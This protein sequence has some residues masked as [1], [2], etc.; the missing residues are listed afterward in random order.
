MKRTSMLALAALS[1]AGAANAAVTVTF[2]KPDTYIDMPFM[3][4]EKDQVL[5]EL[6]A[7]FN[8]LGASLPAGQTL[9]IEMLDID[10]AGRLKPV[11]HTAREL[12][13]LNGGAD[14][15]MLQFRYSVEAAGKVVTSG[16]SRLSD[17]NY[18]RQYNRYRSSEPL[19]YEKQMLDNWYKT[20][21]GGGPQSQ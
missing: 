6:Q 10:L 17:L 3:Q 18:L 16:E 14:W 5:Q 20:A 11:G 19:R 12:R 15:P 13:V 2:T 4:Y 1:L 7:H 21:I 9:K 8:K